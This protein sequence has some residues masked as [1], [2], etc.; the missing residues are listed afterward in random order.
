MFYFMLAFSAILMVTLIIILSV[1]ANYIAALMLAV[2]F[3]VFACV[4]LCN[5]EKIRIGIVLLHTAASFLSEKKTVF[6]AP[7]FMLIF[8]LVF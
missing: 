5:K 8:V 1:T 3:I 2:I 6:L 7:F 4:L